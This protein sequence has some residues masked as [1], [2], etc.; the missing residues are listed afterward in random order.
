MDDCVE[1]CKRGSME[2]WAHAWKDEWLYDWV[3][4]GNRSWNVVGKRKWPKMLIVG[5]ASAIRSGLVWRIF[6]QEAL[7]HF[8]P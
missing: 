2:K 6:E 8:P 1:F 5:C 3:D 4:S 7:N